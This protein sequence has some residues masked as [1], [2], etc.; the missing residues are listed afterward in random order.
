MVRIDLSFYIKNRAVLQVLGVWLNNS[1]MAF[2]IHLMSAGF[3]VVFF[4]I[5]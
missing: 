3:I 2:K 1:G 5:Q 4:H